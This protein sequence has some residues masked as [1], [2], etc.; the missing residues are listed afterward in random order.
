MIKIQLYWIVQHISQN[1]NNSIDPPPQKSYR[2]DMAEMN[3]AIYKPDL[4]YIN[5][6]I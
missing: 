5:N 1:W 4:T 6:K 3:N 2:E